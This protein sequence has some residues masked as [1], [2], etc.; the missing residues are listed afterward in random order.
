MK[1][2]KIP[3]TV[4][5]YEKPYFWS[6]FAKVPSDM[7]QQ[8]S[9]ESFVSASDDM[10]IHAND[11][12]LNT[13][14]VII[15][16]IDDVP[17]NAIPTMIPETKMIDGVDIP[18][19]DMLRMPVKNVVNHEACYKLCQK[20]PQC[21]F[22]TYNKNNQD[23]WLKQGNKSQQISTHGDG[24]YYDNT[25]LPRYD[26]PNMPIK[27][28]ASSDDCYNLCKSK[29]NCHWVNYD[30][31]R[32]NCWLKQGVNRTYTSTQFKPQTHV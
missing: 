3:Y 18:G 10:I 19:F 5:G 21:Q 25:N 22:L 14:Q 2:S 23:C 9:F 13:D 20:D 32:R 27:N 28:V 16:Q 29:P 15:N 17:A 26:M 8:Y 30:S 24:F 11:V 1:R 4:D 31:N 12:H 7:S 6:N